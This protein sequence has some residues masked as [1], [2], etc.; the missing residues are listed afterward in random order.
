MELFA[1][2]Q[3][4]FLSSYFQSDFLGKAIFLGLFLLSLFTWAIV[5][6][7]LWLIF[8]IRRLSI[9]LKQAFSEK[10]PLGLQW[11]RKIKAVPHPF[12]EI[13]KSMKQATLKILML[14]PLSEE[15]LEWIQ[16]EI[17]A[18]LEKQNQKIEKNL[19]ILST[20][21]TLAPFLGLL[22]TVWGILLTFSQL[23]DRTGAMHQNNSMLSGLA[24]ALTTTVLGLIVAIP[25]L[26][27]Y[28]Y[29]KHASQEYRKQMESFAHQLMI[30]LRIYRKKDHA[31][32]PS[33][34]SF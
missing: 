24:L 17:Y 29:L 23:Q 28:N 26:V 30:A 6:H 33:L 10:D 18:T 20:I 21:T 3:N 16:E 15:D 9:E 34:Q 31:K 32:T 2:A 7:K 1:A 13:Y 27:G 11:N 25:A 4:P 5:L 22:G 19:F 12:F 14:S 8:K